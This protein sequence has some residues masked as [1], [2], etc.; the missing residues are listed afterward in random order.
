MKKG[1]LSVIAAYAMWGF[2]PIYFK[3]LHSA[4]ALQIMTHRVVWSFIVLSMV[5]VFRGQFKH[6]LHSITPRIILL[7]FSAGAILA[8]NWFTYVWGVNAGYIIETSLG[9]FINPLVSV[10]LG[11]VILKEPLR[12]FQW[13]P[14]AMAA[15]GVT[16]LTIEHGSIPWIALVLATSFGTYGLLKKIAPLKS[17]EGL[18]LE[19]AG[20]F[21]PAFGFL[22][23]SEF[24]GSGAFGHINPLTTFLLAFSGIVTAIPLIFFA[25][26]TPKVPLTTIG[27]LQYLAPTIQFLIGVFIYHES[28]SFHQLIGFSIIWM[29]LILYSIESFSFYRQHVYAAPNP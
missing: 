25:Y 21:L 11:V 10:L 24:N 18:S 3:F 6:L 29:A 2:F 8:L 17:I 1:I 14:V 20:I 5:I 15:G 9:Y 13:I 7:Y 28:F 19:T 26:G 12:P 16:Y 4:P 22:L 27:I 23:F